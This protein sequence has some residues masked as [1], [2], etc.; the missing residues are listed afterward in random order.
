V[1]CDSDWILEQF[2]YTAEGEGE[3]EGE[4][5]GLCGEGAV[6]GDRDKYKE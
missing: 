5:G 4:R 1:C 3:L 6:G 2:V